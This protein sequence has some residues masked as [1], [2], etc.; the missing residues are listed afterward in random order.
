MMVLVRMILFKMIIF[1]ITGVGHH[2]EVYL[3]FMY[4]VV[5][6]QAS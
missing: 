1:A 5:C 6:S 4:H 2:S 3:H